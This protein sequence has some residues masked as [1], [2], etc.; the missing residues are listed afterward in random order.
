MDPGVS[1]A[2]Y[3]AYRT[4][5]DRRLLLEPS[6]G[7]PH[8][9]R[10]WPGPT[11]FPDFSRPEARQAWAELHAPLLDAGVS[12]PVAYSAFAAAA[13]AVGWGTYQ[14]LKYVKVRRVSRVRARKQG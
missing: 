4:L 13:A 7:T 6:D 10:V 1:V 5:L 3:H 2:D 12:W 8:V 14:V 11:V 9:G